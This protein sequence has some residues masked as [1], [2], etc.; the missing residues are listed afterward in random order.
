MNLEQAR[1]NMVQQQVRTW[2]VLD[3]AVLDALSTLKREDFVPEAYRALAY[4][5]TEIPL[6]PGVSTLPPVMEAHALQALKPR[7]H[8]KALQVGA[9]SGYTAAVLGTLVHQVWVAEPN[10]ELAAAARAHLK[11][12]DVSNVSVEMGEPSA[13]LPGHGPYDLILVYGAVAEVPEQLLEQLKPGGRLF[14]IVGTRPV[15]EACRVT[16]LQDGRLQRETLLETD[17]PFRSAGA[18]RPAFKF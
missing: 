6:A 12:A 5:E 15:L 1:F 7:K 18:A 3:E 16:R 14:A 13:G 10:A 11:Q 2:R 9:G 8:E 4:A 17:V